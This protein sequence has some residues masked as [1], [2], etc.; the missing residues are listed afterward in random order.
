MFRE[1]SR[2][3]K[4]TIRF[5]EKELPQVKEWEINKSYTL[6]VEVTMKNKGEDMWEAKGIGGTFQINS[7]K[8]IEEDKVK[9][10]KAKYQ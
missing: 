2:E 3:Y 5:S 10:L 8:A 4:P 9:K 1:T 7:V 6:Q